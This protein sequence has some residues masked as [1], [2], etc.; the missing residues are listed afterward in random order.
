MTSLQWHFCFLL[1]F[2]CIFLNKL[3][4]LQCYYNVINQCY[5]VFI[6]TV[7]LTFSTAQ[8]VH[9]QKASKGLANGPLTP[10]LLPAVH[11]EPAAEEK[12]V[13]RYA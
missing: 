2:P 3:Q 5:L 12:H 9:N 4:L 1:L 6:D 10:Q 7:G 8:S 11:R 13:N